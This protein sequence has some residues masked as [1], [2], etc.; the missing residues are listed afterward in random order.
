MAK[1][2]KSPVRRLL[3]PFRI[4]IAILLG[5]S[6]AAYLV[7]RNFDA[8]AFSNIIWSW[9]STAWI[10]VA[11][12]MMG[13]RDL[14]Y[15]I[16]IRILTG[17]EL[18]WK[19]AFQVIMLW[20]FA[21]SIT[22]SV[23]GGAAIAIFII[24]REGI[25]LGRST[26]VV[27][28]TSLLD[29]LF[30]ITMVPLVLLFTGSAQLFPLDIEKSFF[31]I[32]LHTEA[33]FWVGYFFILL[34]TTIIL[35]ALFFFPYGFKR[36]LTS[37]FSIKWLRKWKEGAKKTGDDIVTTAIE[38]K[39]KKVR[40]WFQAITATYLSW[41]ARFLVVNFLILAFTISGEHLLIFGRQLAMWV[42]M[43]IS[44]T[45]GSAGVAE[46]AFSGFL[47]EFVPVGLDGTLAL[48]WRTLSFYP[49][50][51]IGAIILPGWLQRVYL[52]RKLIS[53]KKD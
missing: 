22:P 13:L 6:V 23:V 44:P 10:F 48:L 28:I 9:S 19:Q 32:D 31:G 26:A 46:M 20:E 5:L 52:K 17:G 41:F 36:L 8:D 25:R 2:K 21:S 43:L 49:Y 1:K 51:I 12:M 34:L 40:F 7:Y 42:I 53:F 15:I 16:R 47:K 24:N 37:I 3:N 50:L 38:L 27:M 35:T 4:A 11:L 39:K 14:G 29:E 18:N 45:P 30:Y 33:I